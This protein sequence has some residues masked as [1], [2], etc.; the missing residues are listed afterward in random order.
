MAASHTDVQS[1]S[2]GCAN[3]H[4]IDI[5]TVPFLSTVESLWVYRPRTCPVIAVAILVFKKSNFYPFFG[6]KD[7]NGSSC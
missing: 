5:H 3:M 7:Q 6:L 2:L 1:Y 4:P